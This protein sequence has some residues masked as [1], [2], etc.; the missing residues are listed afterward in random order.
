MPD[1]GRRGREGILLQARE[2]RS[3]L[4]PAAHDVAADPGPRRH[5]RD[6]AEG[7]RTLERL[8][9]AVAAMP[10]VV[11]AGISTNAHSACQRRRHPDRDSRRRGA[12]EA[13]CPRQLRQLRILS[14]AGDSGVAG[15][16]LERRRNEARRHAGRDRIR[17]WPA[18]TGRTA[19]VVG[20]QFRFCEHQGRAAV[21]TDGRRWQWVAAGDRRRRR[22]PQRRLAQSDQACLL[23]ALYAEDADVHADPRAHAGSAACRLPDAP[24]PGA[25][26]GV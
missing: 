11:S 9:A 3:R 21:F 2:C 1:R 17:P 7:P 8:R 12:R 6:V 4:Q 19:D 25:G 23:R 26:S 14:A 15:P 10:Q 13:G 24:A 20:R 22:C 16:P 5:L 18:S